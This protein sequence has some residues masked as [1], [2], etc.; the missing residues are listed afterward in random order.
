MMADTIKAFSFQK[1]SDELSK[2]KRKCSCF[3]RFTGNSLVF[4]DHV[5]ELDVIAELTMRNGTN[6]SN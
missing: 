1:A 4:S 5:V 3:P 2:K 6:A